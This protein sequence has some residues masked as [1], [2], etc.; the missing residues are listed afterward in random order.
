MTSGYR[1]SNL[2]PPT[3]IDE[4]RERIAY[5]DAQITSIQALLESTFRIG[6]D[7]LPMTPEEFFQW[8]KRTSAAMAWFLRERNIVAAYI[9]VYEKD[10]EAEE[11]EEARRLKEEAKQRHIEQTRAVQEEYTQWREKAIRQYGTAKLPEAIRLEKEAEIERARTERL[12]QQA[13]VQELSEKQERNRAKHRAWL[14]TLELEESPNSLDAE[15]LLR[16]AFRLLR[17]LV[18]QR[19]VTLSLEEFAVLNII[20]QRELVRNT[21]EDV[22]TERKEP[23]P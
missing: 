7:G 20:E 13:V 6:N 1:R 17:D 18:K 15:N 23:T 2:T 3:S 5:V 4:A 9:K 16:C 12:K 14:R 8:R 10:V 11:K 22:R 21:L 19:R